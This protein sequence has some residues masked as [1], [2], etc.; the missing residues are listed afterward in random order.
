VK[1]KFLAFLISALG[2]RLSGNLHAPFTLPLVMS[3][4]WMGPR[5]CLDMLV[6]RKYVLL[7][8]IGAQ[9]SLP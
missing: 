2:G 4:G 7:P 3:G 9:A 5:F 8:G 1:L 6:K